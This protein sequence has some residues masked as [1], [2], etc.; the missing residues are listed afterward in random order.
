MVTASCEAGN[1]QQST[2]QVDHGAKPAAALATRAARDEVVQQHS[3]SVEAVPKHTEI[4][5]GIGAVLP[6]DPNLFELRVPP[7]DERSA[8]FVAT[9]FRGFRAL[10]CGIEMV[11][12]LL[13]EGRSLA[14][15]LATLLGR[16]RLESQFAAY[17]SRL[18]PDIG[19]VSPV[20]SQFDVV[21]VRRVARFEDEHKFMGR[22]VE[23]SHP[24]VG[25]GPD[26]EIL[27][28]GVARI[29]GGQDFLL[30]AP[31]HA[32]E[33]DGAVDRGAGQMSEDGAEEGCAERLGHLVISSSLS[34]HPKSGRGWRT[35]VTPC[36]PT[37]FQHSG[38]NILEQGAH[39]RP[40]ASA[41]AET[42]MVDPSPPGDGRQP[43]RPGVVQY[44]YR[45]QA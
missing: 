29:A 32:V 20:L 18:G 37:I 40:E 42:R 38:L 31:V 21:D 19:A 24:A 30:M 43:T 35:G 25:L 36:P 16:P 34:D 33:M 23:R 26:A 11:P 39:H 17:M 6:K 44:G 10:R 13:T 7:D 45:Q 2:D 28:F 12:T 5:A 15:V 14:A 4:A 8:A 9:M 22:S 27:Q 41:A 1:V 3:E